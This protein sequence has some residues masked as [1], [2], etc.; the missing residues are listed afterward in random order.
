M[1]IKKRLDDVIVLDLTAFTLFVCVR[2]TL[3]ASKHEMTDRN[4]IISSL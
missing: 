2:K 3:V 4:L 1:E